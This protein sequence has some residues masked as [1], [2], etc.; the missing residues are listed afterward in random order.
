MNLVK[1]KWTSNDMVEFQTYLESFSKPERVDWT[2]KIINTE[3]KCFAIPTKIIK[4]M[5]KEI[6][7]GNF[8]SFVDNNLT[9][10]YE[11]LSISGF[12]IPKIKDFT[13]MRKYLIDYAVKVDNWA[14]CDLLKFKITKENKENFLKLSQELLSSDKQFVRRIG[15]VILFNFLNDESIDV[16]LNICNTLHDEKEYYVNMCVA[17]LMCEAFIKQR[18]KVVEFLKTHNLNDFTLHKFISKCRDSYRVSQVDKDMLNDL[19]KKDN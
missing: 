3:M 12:L 4:D 10:T 11:N 13:I 1:N 15:L 16:V 17:W 8:L 2:K 9:L 14:H 18:D 6:S 19:K 7:K 5:A